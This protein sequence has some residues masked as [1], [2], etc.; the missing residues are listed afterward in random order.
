MKKE[1]TVVCL[2]IKTPEVDTIEDICKTSGIPV[3]YAIDPETG[4]RITEN[5]KYFEYSTPP[6]NTVEKNEHNVCFYVNC[7]PLILG[8]PDRIILPYT[9]DTTN[10]HKLIGGSILKRFIN[11]MG[12]NRQDLLYKEGRILKPMLNGYWLINWGYAVLSSYFSGEDIYIMAKKLDM[13]IDDLLY[14]RQH[15]LFQETDFGKNILTACKLKLNNQKPD[16][17]NSGIKDVFTYL[18]A[19]DK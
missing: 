10:I 15:N 16:G 9:P 6:V 1:R 18:E 17:Y 12:Q 7:A 14:W 2:G 19:I 13:N 3:V 5:G 4:E 8:D 11:T